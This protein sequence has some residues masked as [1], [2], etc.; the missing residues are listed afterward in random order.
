MPNAKVLAVKQNATAKLAEDMKQ[1]ASGVLVDYR[2][3][4]VEDDTALRVELRKAGV[5]Y[6]VVKNTLMRRAIQGI[7]LED[8]D[9]VLHGTTALAVSADPVAPAKVLSAYAKKSND[10]FSIKAGFIEGRVI[11][12][13]EVSALAELPPKEQLVARLLGGLNSPITGMVNVLSGN[14]RGLTVVLNAISEKK[15]A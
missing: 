3:I 5:S 14:I 4:N 10:A 8:L 15:S 1:A 2:G 11:G 6:R 7:G 12:P 9:P 13:A